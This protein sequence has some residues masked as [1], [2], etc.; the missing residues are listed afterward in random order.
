MHFLHFSSRPTL[1]FFWFADVRKTRLFILSP[2]L[3]DPTPVV[4]EMGFEP[5][6]FRVWA[7]WAT[8]ALFRCI[9]L[10]SEFP[11]STLY[12]NYIKIFKKSQILKINFPINFRDFGKVRP[13]LSLLSLQSSARF[14]S[15]LFSLEVYA[16]SCVLASLL[17]VEALSSKSWYCQLD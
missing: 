3:V 7:W 1:P 17:D 14:L 4:A 10:L 11:F 6:T 5:T 15:L 13:H 2:D 8:S 12:K 16:C 9:V